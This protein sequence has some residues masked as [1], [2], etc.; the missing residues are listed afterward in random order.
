MAKQISMQEA[1]ELCGVST[2]TIRRYIAAGRLTANRVGPRLIRLDAEQ[3]RAQL[4]GQ[5]VVGG[6]AA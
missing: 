1:A 3:V 5:P 6:D 2:K 4:L